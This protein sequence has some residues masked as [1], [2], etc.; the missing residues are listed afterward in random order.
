MAIV[1]ALVPS[2]CRLN[3][4]ALVTFLDA[5]VT[6][7]SQDW[8]RALSQALKTLLSGLLGSS[9]WWVCFWDTFLS[10]G[11]HQMILLT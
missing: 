11:Y 5:L 9:A 1:I 2:L 7:D 10:L 3:Y 4:G 8:P 6:Q